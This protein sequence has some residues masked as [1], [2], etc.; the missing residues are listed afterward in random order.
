ME[1]MGL[2]GSKVCRG[3]RSCWAH[4]RLRSY[5]RLAP[6]PATPRRAAAVRGIRLGRRPVAWRFGQLRAETRRSSPL[7]LLGR[8]VGAYLNSVLP[9]RPQLERP[10]SPDDAPAARPRRAASRH[11]EVVDGRGVVLNLCVAEALLLRRSSSVVRR[12]PLRPRKDARARRER[13]GLA[14]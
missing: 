8:A 6:A 7:Q 4:R 3:I 5:W 10:A 1:G 12:S 9:R 11:G 13:L 2:I 14:Y